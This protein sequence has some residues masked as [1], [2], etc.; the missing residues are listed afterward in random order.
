MKIAE[1]GSLESQIYIDTRELHM[2]QNF[3]I[4]RRVENVLIEGDS[5][6]RHLRLHSRCLGPI[7]QQETPPIS[8][9]LQDQDNKENVNPNHPIQQGGGDPSSDIK[10]IV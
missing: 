3:L 6:L 5:Y 9:S 2:G 10:G 1:K 4:V 8:S 7:S